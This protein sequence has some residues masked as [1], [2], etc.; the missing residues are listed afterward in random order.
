MGEGPARRGDLLTRTTNALFHPE[1]SSRVNTS[2]NR[3]RRRS[4][5]DRPTSLTSPREVN[6]TPS[7]DWDEPCAICSVGPARRRPLEPGHGSAA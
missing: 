2:G 5:A 6:S 3:T 4:G 1:H 7:D